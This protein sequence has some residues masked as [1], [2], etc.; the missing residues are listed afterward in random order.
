MR[1]R[2]SFARDLKEKAEGLIRIKRKY[3]RKGR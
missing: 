3:G 2:Q 1:T